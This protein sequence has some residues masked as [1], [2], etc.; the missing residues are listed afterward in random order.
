LNSGN[1]WTGIPPWALLTP[2]LLAV[3]II[4]VVLY[5]VL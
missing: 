5:K 3:G 2:A 1:I 4:A